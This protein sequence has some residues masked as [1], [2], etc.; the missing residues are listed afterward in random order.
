[1]YLRVGAYCLGVMEGVFFGGVVHIFLQAYMQCGCLGNDVIDEA[2]FVRVACHVPGTGLSRVA[3][4]TSFG[5]NLQGLLPPGHGGASNVSVDQQDESPA[6][7]LSK[8]SEKQAPAASQPSADLSAV[9]ATPKTP[10]GQVSTASASTAAGEKSSVAVP[11][12][13]PPRRKGGQS[14]A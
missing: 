3:A 6:A 4:G 11:K 1:M 7:V 10:E 2:V 5:V 8:T 12:Q 13:Q 14:P 9:A